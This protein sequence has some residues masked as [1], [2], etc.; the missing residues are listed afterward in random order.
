MTG[1]KVLLETGICQVN[2]EVPKLQLKNTI[3]SHEGLYTHVVCNNNDS[4]SA[5]II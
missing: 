4:K 1:C 3:H 2:D 5:E